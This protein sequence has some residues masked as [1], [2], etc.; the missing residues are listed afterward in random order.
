MKNHH[1]YQLAAMK[2]TLVERVLTG[3][4]SVTDAAR[5]VKKSRPTIY[6]W[7]T[8]YRAEGIAG[9]LPGKTGSVQGCCGYAEDVFRTK[10]GDQNRHHK[11]LLV[12]RHTSASPS[13]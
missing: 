13:P 8:R 11:L 3:K 7:M 12:C 1:A 9:L 2:G 6:D 4:L 5:S 10:D